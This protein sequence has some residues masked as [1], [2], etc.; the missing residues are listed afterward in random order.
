MARFERKRSG[1]QQVSGDMQQHW[2]GLSLQRVFVAC[3]VCEMMLAPLT[4]PLWHLKTMEQAA[5]AKSSFDAARMLVRRHGLVG[6]YRGAAFSTCG[7]LP[8]HTAYLLSYEWSKH[9]AGTLMP[10]YLAPGAAAVAAECVFVLMAQPIEV[11]TVRTQC[12]APETPPFRSGAACAEL[13]ALWQAGGIR[14]LYRG[15]LLSLA[16]ALPES[17]LWWLI[18]ENTKTSLLSKDHHEGSAATAGSCL[19]A[20]TCA[21]VAST[22]LTN[23]VDVLKSRAQAGEMAA[24]LQGHRLAALLVKGL[25]PRLL[26]AGIEGCAQ[27][28]AYEAV[29]RFGRA[30]VN[31]TTSSASLGSYDR[32]PSAMAA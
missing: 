18:Y 17:A 8:A 30:T 24:Q 23:P 1:H 19:A 21:S 22:A 7:L 31:S 4:Y 32:G 25:L 13:R 20:A 15:S 3:G 5:L 14:N 12:A 27:S 10:S 11:V 2:Q 28:A 29:M 16:T 6:L 26:V 9:H